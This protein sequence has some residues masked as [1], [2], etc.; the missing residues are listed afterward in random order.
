LLNI[1]PRPIA[2]RLKQ[3]QSI[4]ADGFADVTVMFADIIN[5]TRLSE[6]MSPRLMVGLLNEVFSHFDQLAEKYGIEKIKTIG[7]AY[8]VAGGLDEHHKSS[9]AAEADA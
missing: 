3:Q 1:L 2:Q 8:M 6:E 9:S 7:D 5:F 4:I